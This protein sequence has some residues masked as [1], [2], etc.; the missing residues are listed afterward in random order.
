[1]ALPLSNIVNVQLNGQPQSA[2]RRDFGMLALFTPEAGTVFVDSKTR[3]MYAS[4]QQQVEHAFGSYSKTAAATGRF[5]AQSPRPKQLMVARWNRFKQ[6]IAASPTTLTSGPIAQ[7]ETWYKGVD[8]GCFSIRIYG[9]DVTL[10]KLNFT[11]ATSFSQ[12][13]GVLNNALDEFGVN[14]RFLNGCFELYA[15]VAGGNNAIGYAQQRSPSGTYVGHWLKLE[16]DQARLTIGNNADTIEAETLPEA[17]AALQALTTGWYAAAVADETLTDTQIRSASTWIQAADKKIIGF[18]INSQMHLDFKKTNVFRQLNASGC[19]RTVVLYDTTDPYAVISWLARALSVNF[20]ANNAALTM[21]FKHLPGVAADQLTQTQVAQCVRLGIN[22][23]AYVDDVAMVAE[24]T[25]L[26]GRFF[27]EVHLLDWL[28]DAV[29]KE[30]FAVLHRSP[31]KVPLTDAGTH[32][33]IAACKKVCQEGVRNGAFSPGLW[34]GQAFGALATGDY[35]EAGFYV[36]ADSVD[37]L[38][39]SDRQARR[40]PPLQIAVKLAGA[41]HAVDVLIHFDR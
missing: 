2:T 41:I 11:T 5:F 23:Y 15:A 9:V 31:T 21:K 35:L 27:D 18:T 6:H 34:N 24:G 36:W 17:F 4:S 7:A 30:V 1:M 32:L 13:A 33:L 28:V 19:D 16:A 26:G 37:T 12:V 39:T 40:A 3:F 10:S 22:Y 25:C 20:S 38:S 14:C 29:Q 8:D